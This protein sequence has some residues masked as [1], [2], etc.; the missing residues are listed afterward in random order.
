MTDTRYERATSRA[1]RKSAGVPAAATTRS[2]PP[3]RTS[4]PAST[5]TG[6][7]R[8]HLRD[9]VCRPVPV[10]R[11]HVRH[12]LDP[13]PGPGDRHRRCHRQSRSHGLGCHGDGDALSIGGNH[14]IHAMRRNVN[15]KMLLFNNQIYGSPR[16]STPRPARSASAPRPARW[17][18]S[19]SVQPGQPGARVRGHVRG[20]TIDMD[21]KH[22]TEMLQAAYEHEGRH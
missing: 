13:R 9:R 2:W 7:A 20:R 1:T 16:A 14:L 6:E 8:V 4:S 12:A 10:L 18:R 3:S 21:R 5:S 15:V 11:G 17:V 19:T 22:T